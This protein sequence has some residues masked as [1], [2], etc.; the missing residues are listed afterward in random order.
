MLTEN[1]RNKNGLPQKIRPQS[2]SM[3]EIRDRCDNNQRSYVDVKI[4][5]PKLAVI[6]L[7]F[8][9]IRFVDKTVKIFIN[10]NA[11]NQFTP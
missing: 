6:V 7:S 4:Q 3:K 2:W 5:G 8:Q 9:C 1:F 10:S 11:R